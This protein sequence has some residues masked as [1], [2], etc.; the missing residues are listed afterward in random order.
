MFFDINY[1]IFVNVIQSYIQI[2]MR[3]KREAWLLSFFVSNDGN[4]FTSPPSIKVRKQV[5]TTRIH[6]AYRPYA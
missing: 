2:I 1:S 3:E 4:L 5:D 6:G